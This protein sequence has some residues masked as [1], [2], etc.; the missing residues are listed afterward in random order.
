MAVTGQNP[1]WWP[2]SPGV[3]PS[4]A[5]PGEIFHLCEE[6][7]QRDPAVDLHDS[8]QPVGLVGFSQIRGNSVFIQFA[9]GY[10]IRSQGDPTEVSLSHLPDPQPTPSCLERLQS[11]PL[12][13]CERDFLICEGLYFLVS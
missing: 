7:P 13:S 1:L 10:H 2:V 8:R 9:S 12:D 5:D 3:S 6:N 4:Q 11:F